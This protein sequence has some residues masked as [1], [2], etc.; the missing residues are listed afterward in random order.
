MNFQLKYLPE[1][2]QH[3]YSAW[4][5]MREKQLAGVKRLPHT[6]KIKRLF[7]IEGITGFVSKRGL[8][9]MILLVEKGTRKTKRESF[10]E[11]LNF[12]SRD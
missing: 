4:H 8:Y 5:L 2:N 6:N 7:R 3:G 10:L 1:L 12:E 11:E 9:H